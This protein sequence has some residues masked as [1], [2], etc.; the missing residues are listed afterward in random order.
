MNEPI[1]Q[2][3]PIIDTEGPTTGRDDLFDNWDALG[4]AMRMLTTET[5]VRF[6]DSFG[7][8][9]KYSWD[10]LDWTGY[11]SDDHEFRRRGHDNRLHGVWNFYRSTILTDAELQKTGDGIYWHYHHPPKDGS[12]GWNDDWNDSAWHEYI[13]AKRMLDFRFF[14]AVYRA[15]KYVENNASSR[16][17]ERW[18]PFD[19]SSISPAKREFCDWSRAP[20]DWSPY[21]PSVDDYQRPGTMKRL[22]ARSL[23]VAAKGGSG[24]L[25]EEEVEKAFREAKEKGMALFSFHSHDYYKSIHSDFAAACGMVEKMSR[26][27]RIPWKFSNALEAIRHYAEPVS[28]DFFLRLERDGAEVRITSSHA[29]F[30][31]MPFVALEYANG[32]TCRV[33]VRRKDQSWA[34]TTP[35]GA[36]RIAA[37]AADQYGNTDVKILNL[38]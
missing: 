13:I 15:G 28:G 22:I 36:V 4:E 21:H 14:P 12:W 10:I 19:F 3:V 31:E 8:P 16:W 17:L 7:S 11:S 27:F 1:V 24:T 2:V 26:A 9:L 6:R 38:L 37:G 34:L 32:D 33:D 29:I 23:P 20:A 18:I 35:K 25:Q 30:G 5:R